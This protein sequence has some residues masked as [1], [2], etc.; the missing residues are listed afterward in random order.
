MNLV[1]LVDFDPMNHGVESFDPAYEKYLS[2]LE[3][4]REHCP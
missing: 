3:L 2:V 4:I 1:D